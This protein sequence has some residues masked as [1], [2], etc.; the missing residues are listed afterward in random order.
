MR[1][2]LG[3]IQ[4]RP[5]GGTGIGHRITI[6]RQKRMELVTEPQ[7]DWN[8]HG[9][10]IA[11]RRRGAEWIELCDSVRFSYLAVFLKLSH[12]RWAGFDLGGIPPNRGA[13]PPLCKPPNRLNGRILSNIFNENIFALL[14]SN[15]RGEA[16]VFTYQRSEPR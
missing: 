9:C 15:G 8:H 2:G 10:T 6:E 12:C 11:P 7:Q 1:R 5:L 14:A 16:V 3:E 4:S 13:N